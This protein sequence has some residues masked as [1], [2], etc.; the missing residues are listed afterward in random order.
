LC[1]RYC[2]KSAIFHLRG[3][4]L[5]GTGLLLFKPFMNVDFF[6][7]TKW[8][9]PDQKSAFRYVCSQIH[10]RSGGQGSRSCCMY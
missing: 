7:L 5:L 4:F 8:N 2:T 10:N 6:V 3:N 1:F 9:T